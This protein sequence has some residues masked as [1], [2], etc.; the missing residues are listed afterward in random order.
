MGRVRL[1]LS[2]LRVENIVVSV[3]GVVA[4]IAHGVSDRSEPL[5]VPSVQ[6]AMT[7]AATFEKLMLVFEALTVG[8][9]AAKK[10]GADEDGVV[11]RGSWSRVRERN[12][13]DKR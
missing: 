4:V 13:A 2:G 10:V 12:H 1:V 7:A 3:G 11:R 8:S 5:S 9:N 6:V